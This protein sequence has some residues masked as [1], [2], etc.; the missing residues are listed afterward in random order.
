MNARKI[1]HKIGKASNYIDCGIQNFV[2]EILLDNQANNLRV[3]MFL[4]Q[5]LTDK[6]K[7]LEEYMEGGGLTAAEH[8]YLNL[9]SE[10]LNKMIDRIFY[11]KAVKQ[12]E[13]DYVEDV[14]AIYA[15]AK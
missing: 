3:R 2:Q 13:S 5:R 6:E 10:E 9:T 11:Q 8:K 7:L 12:L 4:F 14:S 1:L 15:S